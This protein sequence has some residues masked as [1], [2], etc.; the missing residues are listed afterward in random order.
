MPERPVRVLVVDDHP[1]YRHGL[2]A[3]LADVPDVEVA[4][5]AGDGAQAVRAVAELAP[6]VILMDVAMPVLNGVEA[7][8]Q[9]TAAHPEAAVLML[10]MSA[11]DA[12]LFAAMRAGA[13]GYLLKEASPEEIGRA[14][15]AAANG[16]VVF[17]SAM[18]RRV[19]GIFVG[20]DG[21]AP[22]LAFPQLTSREHEVLSLMAR[23]LTN[24]QIAK[25]LSLS[26]KTI[27]NNVSN[28]VAKLQVDDRAEA[29]AAAREAGLAP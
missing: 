4:G 28:I 10:T 20:H 12:T 18:A 23:G 7:T 1:V 3:L 8:R 9:I 16:G 24:S 6:D 5:T 15:M 25:R 17:G 22:P 27:R 2:A 21:G 26:P 19:T 29:M 11:D 14:V 13:T